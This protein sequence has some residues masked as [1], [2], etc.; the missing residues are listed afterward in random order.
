M[1]QIEQLL[2][3]NLHLIRDLTRIPAKTLATA[4]GPAAFTISRQARGIDQTPVHAIDQPLPSIR[5]S[6][7]LCEQTND[8]ALL[9]AALFQ[10]V[11]KASAT[12]RIMGLAMGNVRLTIRYADGAT[13]SRNSMLQPPLN[14]DLSLYEKCLL[15]LKKCFTRRIRL[16]DLAIECTNLTFP[17]G[18]IDL[19]A[20]T[21]REEHLMSALDTIRKSYGSQ[22]IK[23]WG[24]EHLPA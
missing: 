3:F 15:L 1:R 18:Q 19:F 8:E 24:R 9:C 5:E 14:G 22:A 4:L 20:Q 13:V 2:Q 11:A 16:T 17:Y 21:D 23:F 12:A 10:I 7:T 6:I